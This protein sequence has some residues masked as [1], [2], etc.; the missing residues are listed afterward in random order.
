MTKQK[1][2]RKNRTLQKGIKILIIAQKVLVSFFNRETHLTDF[3]M[4]PI[5]Q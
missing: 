5:Y 2:G 1:K 4:V 3:I